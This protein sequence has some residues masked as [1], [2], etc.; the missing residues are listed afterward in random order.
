[1]KYDR[2]N[3]LAYS[4]DIYTNDIY[5]GD[6]YADEASFESEELGLVYNDVPASG[7]Y[8][9]EAA[10]KI[11]SV[12]DGFDITRNNWGYLNIEYWA[13]ISG[14]T[15]DQII[16]FANGKLMWRDP[17]Q[18]ELEADKTV[19]WVTREQILKGNRIR[20]LKEARKIHEKYGQLEE[21]IKLLQENLPEEVAGED[22]HVNMGATWVLSI[23][24]FIAKFIAELLDMKLLPDVHYD[25]Y[26]GKSS[27]ECKQDPNYVLN[28]YTY[29][30]PDMP[31][32]RI[33]EHKL[34]AKPIKVSE[35]LYN[36]ET[37]NYESVVN[38]G[39]T[40]A[41]QE[42]GK[43]VDEKFQDFC[44]GNKRNED[45]LQE[46]YTNW[47][48]YGLCEFNGDYLKLED[49]G[50]KISLYKHQKDAVAH[51]MACHNVLLAHNVGSGK[52]YEYACGI[53]ELIRLGI[54]KKAVVAVPNT[55]L[56]AAGSA[57]KELFP[58]DN[59][60]ICRPRKEFSPA[61]R[62]ETLDQIKNEDQVVVFMAY[63]SFDM[64]TMSRDYAFA[65]KDAQLRECA[66]QLANA[67]TYSRRCRLEAMYKRMLKSVKAYKEAF[68]D[69]ETACFDDLNFDI[70]VCDEA[71]NYKNISLEYSADNIVG[72]HC[73]G[74]KKADNMLE[75]VRYVQEKDGR[76]IFATGTPI[77]NSLAD[78]YVLQYYLQPEELRM[79]NINHF[80]DWI[81]TFCEEEHSFE[82]DV[83]SKNCRFTTRFSRFHNL[84]ELMSMFS[85]VCDF[86]QGDSVE[87]GLPDFNG[88]TDVVVA[89]SQEQK[90]YI[91]ELATRT[92]A[93]RNHEVNRKEDNLLKITV[94]GRQAALDIR[95]VKPELVWA[96][97][98]NKASV[99]AGNMARMY[100]AYPDKCQIAF[101]DISTPKEGF[102]IYDELKKELV[103]LG[104]K[105]SEIAFVHDAVTE[106]QRAKLEKKFN[107]G[108]IRILIGSTAKLGTGSNVQERLIAEHHID[109]P[110]RPADMVQREG[111]II[112]QGN[113]C[114]EVY[115][116]RY[117]TECS[118]DA[119]T[120]QILENKQ[121][122]IAQFLSGS[123]SAVHRDESDCADTILT[124]AE[125]KALAIGNPLIKER[126]EVSNQLE[127]ARIN[128]RQKR[129][130]LVSLEE[131]Q[132]RLP[133]VISKRKLLV[134]NTKADV[135]HYAECKESVNREERRSF[136]EELLLALK[137]NVMRD[138]DRLFS[139]YQGFDV[140][141]PK[142]MEY[143]K[144]YVIL[145]REGSNQYSVPMDGDKEMGVCQRLDHCLE[146]LSKELE[147][148][149]NKLRE[150][151]VQQSQ[152]RRDLSI[153]NPYDDE[154]TILAERLK[155][156]D[157]KLK[158]G[159]AA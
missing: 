113:T 8:D 77:T 140:M 22:I 118:F 159:T 57:Y 66:R 142:H 121:K 36:F 68:K 63:S 132:E 11:V 109:V 21:V 67:N 87:L 133:G 90:E 51:I 52:T 116:F 151:M 53:H 112:R 54:C 102:N 17:K 138:K 157:E 50:K 69:T 28:N 44:H 39:K 125:I 33:I 4:D 143:D 150:L 119:Y 14:C 31:C 12:E 95:L 10:D 85:E 100:D 104:V 110:W 141:L 59:V 94:Q 98:D 101:S 42:K 128:Q 91:D 115:I 114:D 1:V 130:E 65:K 13:D 86:Y 45:R 23:E 47:Y 146:N 70:L 55:T 61:R 2:N 60:L 79:C 123:L 107:H 48:G 9:E 71:H 144:A 97:K 62:K 76:I 93:I 18:I 120:Y 80:N 41:A 103:A 149:Q 56:D 74:S 3:E 106:A 24:G 147:R 30:M 20:K 155:E 148:H 134:A 111:R 49:A 46:A 131:L 84:T 154:V 40:L 43:F 158:E 152:A 139:E 129:K 37:G 117:I 108:E 29:G 34:N 16:E 73:K 156:I 81:N 15:V 88:Y 27:I 145:R 136:G 96:T 58:M 89:K 127:H 135:S 26:R 35:Q 82:I 78:L 99:C 32:I 122:F 5:T 92:E 105:E 126:V 72:M 83:D 6:I 25:P 124:Y 153:G 137:D 64:L 75:K 38:K 19:G 7:T